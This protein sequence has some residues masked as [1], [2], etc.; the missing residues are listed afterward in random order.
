MKRYLLTVSLLANLIWIISADF[1]T[2]TQEVKAPAMEK[3]VEKKSC[4]YRIIEF[5]KGINCKG[6]TIR[7]EKRNGIQVRVIK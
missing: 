2:S 5:G 4:G 1:K 7:L 6:D 3:K